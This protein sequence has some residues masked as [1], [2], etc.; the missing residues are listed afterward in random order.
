METAPLDSTKYWGFFDP[1]WPLDPSLAS[2]IRQLTTEASRM[3]WEERITAIPAKQDMM[4]LSELAWALFSETACWG[5]EGAW[6]SNDYAVGQ[7]WL[8]A[9][10]PSVREDAAV[11]CTYGRDASILMTWSDFLGAWQN[12]VLH[13]DE[14]VLVVPADGDWVLWFDCDLAHVGTLASRRTT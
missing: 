2:R 12:V 3:L 14:G 6:S 13:D 8:C 7:D 10:L 11:I 9:S 5:W 4:S 1:E